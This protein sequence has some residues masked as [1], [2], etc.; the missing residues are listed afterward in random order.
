MWIHALNS[1]GY[2]IRSGIARSYENNFMFE[3]FEEHSNCFP[4]WLCNFT[5]PPAVY[6]DSNFS[7]PTL[8]IIDLS[9][10]SL[11]RLLFFNEKWLSICGILNTS[12]PGRGICKKLWL[13][14]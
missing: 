14:M 6:D 3:L 4:N 11:L 5:L 13:I 12:S 10:Y 9:Y 1:L 2:I 7:R 8:V